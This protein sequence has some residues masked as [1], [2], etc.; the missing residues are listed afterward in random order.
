MTT[1]MTS[2]LQAAS[3]HDTEVLRSRLAG[4]VITPDDPTYE[5]ARTLHNLS[6]NPRPALI[7]RARATADVAESV[8]FARAHGYEL[9]VRS[10]G[11]SSAG[12]SSVDDAL[13]VDLSEL[14]ALTIDQR[15][16]TVRIGAGATSGD[17]AGPAHAYGL[18]LS[19]G[20][21]SS[22][23]LGGL[24]TGGGIGWMA[25]K[26]GLAID[27]LLSAEV[28]TAE[29]DILRASAKEHSDLFWAIRG[30]GGNF[31]IVT[32]FEFQLWKDGSVLGGVIGL[33]A[34]R[35]VIRGYMQ[36][37]LDAADELTTIAKVM[38][39]PPAPF[40]PTDVV[41]QT[42][43]LVN[44]VWAGHPVWGA[45][46]LGPLRQLARP[47]FDTVAHMPYPAMFNYTANAAEASYSAVK[48]MFAFDLS[49]AS[50]DT[51]INQV[52]RPSGP[53]SM[54]EIRP[55][56]GAIARV[57]A[58]ATAF[59]HRDK[60][61]LVAAVNVWH[62]AEEDASR[63]REWTDATF[64]ALR[65]DASGAYS[66]FLGDEGRCRVR[67]AYEGSTYARLACVKAKYDP[68]NLFQFNQNIKPAARLGEQAA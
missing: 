57:P 7:V 48:G 3:A 40:V 51:I 68:Q 1:N 34:T 62:G 22:V 47:L 32:E 10:G 30:G 49:D 45:R 24:V 64:A 13:V 50:L 19:T 53:L 9:A 23:G 63:H 6:H 60:N 27:N 12:H 31:G 4:Q 8:K 39:A 36:F 67:E 5:E 15:K 11:H 33:P 21:T 29:G 55:L 17:L 38:H 65:G 18:A 54:V 61:Y 58:D 16:K 28:V 20:D 42:I 44:V 56:G 35:E 2:L 59:V 66:N 37:A 41:G 52:E 46:A 25:R 26:H 43:L 14:K